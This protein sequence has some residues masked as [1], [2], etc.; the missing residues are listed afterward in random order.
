MSRQ[1]LTEELMDNW[2]N[3]WHCNKFEDKVWNWNFL[4]T[5]YEIVNDPIVEVI[6]CNLPLII[7][8]R[9]RTL[10]W[11]LSYIQKSVIFYCPLFF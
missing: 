6:L 11:R 5:R 4:K 2:R 7:Y 1:H 8:I 10:F 3:V 9:P